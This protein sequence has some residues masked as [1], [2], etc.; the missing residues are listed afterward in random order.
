MFY[1]LRGDEDRE[2]MPVAELDFERKDED[3]LPP[4]PSVPTPAPAPTS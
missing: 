4:A 1:V 2:D 3:T